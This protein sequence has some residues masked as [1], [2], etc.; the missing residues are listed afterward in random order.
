MLTP[1]ATSN[2]TIVTEDGEKSK[3]HKMILD[4]FPLLSFLMLGEMMKGV[5]AATG[6]GP[7]VTPCVT[8]VLV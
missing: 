3:A 8:W 6:L 7:N 2:V 4:F 5:V 1:N